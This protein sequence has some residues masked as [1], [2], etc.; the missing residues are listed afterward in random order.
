MTQ[1][2]GGY[3]K[4][5]VCRDESSQMT[6]IFCSGSSQGSCHIDDVISILF[7]LLILIVVLI[8]GLHD[9]VVSDCLCNVCSLL[10]PACKH[11]CSLPPTHRHSG[12]QEGCQ[13]TPP[14]HKHPPNCPPQCRPVLINNHAAAH[15]CAFSQGGIDLSLH[16]MLAGVTWCRLLSFKASLTLSQAALH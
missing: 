5:E 16:A 2:L 1:V 13:R 7:R 10:G 4:Q 9:Q 15:A 8:H 11:C 14:Y 12:E 6:H 3:R